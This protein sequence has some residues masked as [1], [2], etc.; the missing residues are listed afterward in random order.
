MYLVAK[1]IYCSGDKKVEIT[2]HACTG[3][4]LLSVHVCQNEQEN[5]CTT[6]LSIN[7]THVHVYS[8]FLHLFFKIITKLMFRIENS[9]VNLWVFPLRMKFT[10]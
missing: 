9:N 6:E 1:K 7:Q 8:P 3:L 2:R 4:S 10:V 5:T